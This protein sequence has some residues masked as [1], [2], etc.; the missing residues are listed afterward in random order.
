MHS[1]SYGE[2]AFV[3]NSDYNG[4]IIVV[5]KGHS[6]ETN[7]KALEEFLAAKKRME[8]INKIEQGGVS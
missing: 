4:P 8:L 2:T 5:S 6:V 1:S 3:Y 7:I